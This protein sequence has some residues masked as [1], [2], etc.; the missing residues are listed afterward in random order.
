MIILGINNLHSQVAILSQLQNHFKTFH[1]SHDH[2]H[3]VTEFGL[4]AALFFTRVHARLYRPAAAEV[5]GK[6]PPES[7]DL[8]HHFDKLEE[9][10]EKRIQSSKLAA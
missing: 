10:I 9:E 2:R 4:R 3:R 1:S 6:S 8:C 5:I 7:S